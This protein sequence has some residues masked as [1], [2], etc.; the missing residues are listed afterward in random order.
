M[1]ELGAAGDLL[2]G[3]PVPEPLRGLRHDHVD[4][5]HALVVGD[6]ENHVRERLANRRARSR[7][8][9]YWLLLDR[10]VGQVHVEREGS[11]CPAPT[12]TR[13]HRT[14][15]TAATVAS[16]LLLFE[17][18]IR[19]P[20]RKTSFSGADELSAVAQLLVHRDEVP[21]PFSKR[22]LL[23]GLDGVTGPLDQPGPVV[24]TDPDAAEV[25]AIPPLHDVEGPRLARSGPVSVP[26][27][28]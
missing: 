18:M 9:R 27:G 13:P 12:S 17:E 20:F 14:L 2:R 7:P 24:L 10:E 16:V 25:G 22:E 15:S 6:D 3:V 4:G 26:G 28:K 23:P 11:T 1:G 5:V 19:S 8:R 21:T